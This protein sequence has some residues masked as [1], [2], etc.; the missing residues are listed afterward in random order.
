MDKLSQCFDI[1]GFKIEAQ[2]EKS[3]VENTMVP[4]LRLWTTL[5][6]VKKRRIL[7]FLA[8][9]PAA[10]KSIMA[11][12]FAYLSKQDDTL[13]DVQALGMDGFHHYQHYILSH[14]VM[15]DGV[16]VPMKRVKGC[17]ESFDFHRLARLVAEIAHTDRAWPQ[18]NRKL[19]DVEDDKIWVDKNIVLIEGNYLLLNEQPWCELA[20]QC[21]VKIFI[22]AEAHTVKQR[23]LQR[24]LRGGSLPHEAARFYEQSEKRNIERILNHRL[25]SDITIRFDGTR[26]HNITK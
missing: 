9:P 7:I 20:K 4:L 14:D 16:R 22:E 12:F 5:Y 10:G 1:N 26:Y 13:E 17:P 8:A 15:I 23:L 24:K 21:D 2:Y 18:Y 11:E 6:Q 3:F 19:H 25:P